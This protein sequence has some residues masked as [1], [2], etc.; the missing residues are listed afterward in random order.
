MT[1]EI[2]VFDYMQAQ[3]FAGQAMGRPILG[4]GE[5]VRSFGARGVRHYMKYQLYAAEKYGFFA[6]SATLINGSL[7]EMVEKGWAVFSF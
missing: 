6:R 2:F 4:T 1:R 3:A 7:A 5:R